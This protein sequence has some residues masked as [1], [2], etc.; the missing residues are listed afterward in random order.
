MLRRLEAKH[1]HHQQLNPLPTVTTCRKTQLA[2]KSGPPLVKVQAAQILV[3]APLG[4]K[5]A[6]PPQQ[7]QRLVH[8][9]ST[10]GAPA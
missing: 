4:L 7:Q 1:S 6:V 3:M 5:A 9:A 10:A 2:T 8:Q